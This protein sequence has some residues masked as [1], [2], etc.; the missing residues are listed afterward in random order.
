MSRFLRWFA[1]ALLVGAAVAP[2]ALSA[3]SPA[4]SP[5]AIETRGSEKERRLTSDITGVEGWLNGQPID[6]LTQ[7][8]GKVVLLDFWTYSCV[9]C[10]RTLPHLRAWHERYSNQGLVIL[11]IHS[12]EFNFEK[13][14][15]NVE[16][17][18]KDLEVPWPVALDNERKTWDAFH[19]RA[20]PTKVLLGPDGRERTRVIGEGQY[21]ELER[22]IRLLLVEAGSDAPNVPFEASEPDFNSYRG[23]TRE[24]YSGWRW[25][26]LAPTPYLANPEASR[27][28]QTFTFTDPG[29][30]RAS[31]VFFLHGLWE[32]QEESVRHAR[33]TAGH[34]D[35]V[36]IG[37]RARVVN[38]VVGPSLE[39]P[40]RVQVLLDG[41]PLTE[42]N[43]GRDVVLDGGKSYLVVEAPRMYEVVAGTAIERHE[44]R[45][46]P[47]A[48]SFTLHTFTFGP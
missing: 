46:S 8:K 47:Q 30:P 41:Q 14:A 10:V 48:D 1:R 3:C 20:W 12:P 44:L 22:Q 42:G 25:E 31:G 4:G 45:M 18:T 28:D 29:P 32:R 5:A 2:M 35:Y 17:A 40:Q 21:G 43:R 27:P 15:A 16:R 39:G 34:E 13:S 9:N 11:G 24:I 7:L 26:L 38:A 6:S 36:A 37:Y 23:L 33:V 19:V